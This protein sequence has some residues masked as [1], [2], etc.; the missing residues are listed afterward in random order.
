MKRSAGFVLFVAIVL[1]LGLPGPAPSLAAP[2]PDR[3]DV[4]A[5]AVPGQFLVK[6]T[7]GTTAQERAAVVA[8]QGGRVFARAPSSTST[9]WSSLRSCRRV[10]RAPPKHC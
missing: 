5:P 10:T 8:M 4:T 6:F 9:R 1:A 3:A 2:S 7:P